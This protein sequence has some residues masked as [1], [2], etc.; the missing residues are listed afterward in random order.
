VPFPVWIPRRRAARTP[1]WCDAPRDNDRGCRECRLAID[2]KPDHRG[3]VEHQIIALRKPQPFRQQHGDHRAEERPEKE[4]GAA[5]DYHHQQIERERQIEGHRIDI[6][7]Q[8]RVQRAGNTAERRADR[9]RHQRI[10]A[11]IDAERQRPDRILAQREEGAAPGRADQPPQHHRDDAERAEAQ[12]IERQRPVGRKAEH[13]RPRNVADAVDALGQPVL[14]AEHQK[15]QRRECERHEGQIMVLYPQRRIAEQPAHR[16]A[17]HDGDAERGD[18]RHALRGHDR[19]RIGAD[20]DEG[21]LGQR[22][23]PGIAKRQIESHGGDGH[24]RPL[25]QDEQSVAVEVHGHDD[26]PRNHQDAERD[27]QVFCGRDHIVRSSARPRIPCG[28]N[29]MMAINRISGT[30]A[31]YCVET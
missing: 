25:A 27:A 13:G 4:T 10:A 3:G 16:K 14:V 11:G 8:R 29:R 17:Q 2:Q 28:R 30:A 23:L 21:A 20:A 5:D 22:D 24:H 26:Q 15:R 9:K 7:R 12:I 31:R 19:S 6:L 18:Q 1:S